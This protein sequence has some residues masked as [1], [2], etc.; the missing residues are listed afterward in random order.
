MLAKYPPFLGIPNLP[1]PKSRWSLGIFGTMS[2]SPNAWI[3]PLRKHTLDIYTRLNEAQASGDVKA[4]GTLVRGRMDDEVRQRIR[5]LPKGQMMVWKI[6]GEAGPTQCLSIRTI[7]D[8]N[9]G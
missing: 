2:T 5:D 1:V 4:I 7:D 3:A 6:H 8:D 9:M